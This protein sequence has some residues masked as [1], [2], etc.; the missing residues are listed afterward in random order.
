MS[1]AENNDV[2]IDAQ[3][4]LRPLHRIIYDTIFALQTNVNVNLLKKM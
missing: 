2:L 4:G 3:F 1:G